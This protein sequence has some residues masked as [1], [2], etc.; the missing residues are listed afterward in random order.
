M[1]LASSN[2]V[3]IDIDPRNGGHITIEEVEARHGPLRSE[4]IQLTGGG[5]DDRVFCVPAGQ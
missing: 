2:L 5:G 4:V 3:A 1:V